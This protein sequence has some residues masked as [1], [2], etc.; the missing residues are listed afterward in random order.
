VS[1]HRIAI[2]NK[3]IGE[4]EPCF[5]IAEVGLAHEGS[6]GC[7]FAYIDAIADAGADAVKFQTHLAD[8]E[9]TAQE[10]FRV[11]VF[12]QDRLRRDY[13]ERT[14]FSEGEWTKLRE[15]AEAR[16]LVFMSSPFS[17]EAVRLLRKVG[18]AAW[19]IASGEVSNI[20]MLREI[21]S[22]GQP[23]LLSTGMSRKA[24]IEE[25]VNVVRQSN[26]DL[27]LFQC[28]SRYPCPPEHLGLNMIAEYG[29]RYGVPVGFSDHSG[30]PAAAIAAFSLGACSVEVHVTFSR[31]CFG[32]DV[33]SS[34]TVE[35]LEA[36]VRG[37]RYLEKAFSS[38]VDKEEEARDLESVRA[39]FT[40]SLVAAA[41]LDAG[42]VLT[43]DLFGL[44][45]PRLGIPAEDV[46]K[47][48]GKTLVRDKK[49]D[50]FITWDDVQ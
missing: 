26:A 17:V 39:L 41:N 35:E 23:V 16:D 10:S 2:R 49:K 13:W 33:S 6:L 44:K 24:E 25:A 28:T 21:A 1:R 42:T 45:K 32:P 4:G 3:T 5:V 46:E 11:P 34:L 8:F 37:I 31:K 29:K 36:T 20:P 43:G 48:V 50:D 19:K 47:V 15:H 40:K 7:A 22:T 9:S 38:P 27:V 12:P 18:M 14:A 30:E